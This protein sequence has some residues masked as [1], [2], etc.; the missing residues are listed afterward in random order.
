MYCPL[1]Y[2]IRPSI[3][4]FFLIITHLKTKKNQNQK[5]NY[6]KAINRTDIDQRQTPDRNVELR[7]P[8]LA[9]WKP[10]PLH[11]NNIF[12]YYNEH[13]LEPDQYRQPMI[14]YGYQLQQINQIFRVFATSG[15]IRG[16]RGFIDHLLAL[17]YVC[18][19]N[20]DLSDNLMQFELKFIWQM[21]IVCQTT[22]IIFYLL[23]PLLSLIHLFLTKYL[24]F[25]QSFNEIF[26]LWNFDISVSNPKL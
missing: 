26:S 21:C 14:D 4:N 19:L 10:I 2:L 1:Q 24:I 25:Y 11:S 15:I 7:K 23:R 6:K 8:S 18:I 3:G 20:Y 9:P 5:I 12:M 16:A 22:K 17:C 13:Y